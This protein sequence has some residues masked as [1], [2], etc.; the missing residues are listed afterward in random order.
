MPLFVLSWPNWIQGSIKKLTDSIDHHNTSNYELS[1]NVKRL[2]RTVKTL[3]EALHTE[4]QSSYTIIGV[5]N[6]PR[7]KP[8]PKGV[9]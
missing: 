5:T 4:Q 3:V 1:N 7:P 6:A 8:L 9:K 2:D